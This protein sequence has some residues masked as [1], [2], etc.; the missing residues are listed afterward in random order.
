VN[1]VT[2]VNYN[3]KLA[4]NDSDS[5]EISVNK[6]RQNINSCNKDEHALSKKHRVIL[7][8]DSNMKGYGCNL[9]LLLSKNYE[10]Y[11]VTKPGSGSS[12]LNETAKEEISQLSRED[13]IVIFSGTNDYELNE[14]SLT[15]QN[16]TRFIQ[17][18]NHTN[19]I[20]INVP[21]RYDLPNS[22]SVN[23]SISILNRKL[24]KLMKVFPHTSFL[25]TV[26]N[27]NLF[28]N[29]GLHLNT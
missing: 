6:L 5:I 27:R 9:K 17:T 25:E 10:L 22:A 4:Q 14:F 20:L 19:I 2:S 3:A 8:G 15:L 12:E 26:N 7:I 18:N 16:I 13:A 21:L 29:H 11:S 28:T 1:G 23:S 24:K